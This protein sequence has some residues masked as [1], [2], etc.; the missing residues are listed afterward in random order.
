MPLFCFAVFNPRVEAVFWQFAALRRINSTKI[1]S[2]ERREEA[3]QAKN[4]CPNP[5]DAPLRRVKKAP[6]NIDAVG[7]EEE[8]RK[9]PEQSGVRLHGYFTFSALRS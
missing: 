6:S 8:T 4:D 5:L 3:G 1:K 7:D 9:N 2:Y